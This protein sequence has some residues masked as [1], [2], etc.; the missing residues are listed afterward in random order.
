MFPSL[1]NRPWHVFCRVSLQHKAPLTQRSPRFPQL[2]Y[3]EESR[4]AIIRQL[5]L[6]T[7]RFFLLLWNLSNRCV[8]LLCSTTEETIITHSVAQDGR[9]EAYTAG[10]SAFQNAVLP[11]KGWARYSTTLPL[12]TIK[13]V[14]Q[15]HHQVMLHQQKAFC[16]LLQKP[17]QLHQVTNLLLMSVC[18]PHFVCNCI[19]HINNHYFPC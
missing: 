7:W 2:C 5:Q 10:G 15:N 14:L 11:L 13:M 8:G 17:P 4:S 9:V 3:G 16:L 1:A 12:D 6:V 19:V 18:S